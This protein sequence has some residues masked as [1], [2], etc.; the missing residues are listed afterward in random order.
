MSRHGTSGQRRR[1][2]A[3]AGEIDLELGVAPFRDLEGWAIPQAPQFGAQ[4]AALSEQAN[5]REVERFDRGFARVVQIASPLPAK[6]ANRWIDMN[7]ELGVVLAKHR[8]EIIESWYEKIRIRPQARRVDRA[9]VIN[10]MP[11][12]VETIAAALSKPHAFEA[13]EAIDPG[14]E[15]EHGRTRAD[16]GYGLEEVGEEY[17]SLREAMLECLDDAGL[18]VDNESARALHSA[19]DRAHRASVGC[20]IHL[21]QKSLRERQSA[22]LARLAHDF[23]TPLSSVLGSMQLLRRTASPSQVPVLDR[24]ERATRRILLLIE[25]Q[26]ATEAALAGELSP[27]AAEF[28]LAQVLSD[29]VQLVEPRAEAKGLTIDLAL[30]GSLRCVSDA[31]LVGQIVQNLLDN[32]VKYTD[33]GS[34]HLHAQRERDEIVIQVEDTGRGISKELLPSVF[35]MYQ[36]SEYSSPG[37]GIGLAVVKEVVHALDGSISV[38]SDEDHGTRFVVR[39]PARLPRF[40]VATPSPSASPH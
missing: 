25:T 30:P 11:D 34:V 15:K 8:D 5:E 20:F 7:P 22:F 29:V 32:A 4:A 26:L 39:L 1:L 18:R 24:A 31:T 28:D 36:R 3:T 19:I 37:H 16:L 13:V 2:L 6:L 21:Q 10:N 38:K 14:P 17:N 27:K 23:R 9:L 40:E 12:I 35:E 33:R